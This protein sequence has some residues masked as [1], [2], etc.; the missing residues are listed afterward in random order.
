MTTAEP[1]SPDDAEARHQ[2]LLQVIGGAVLDLVPEHWRRADLVVRMAADERDSALTIYSEDRTAVQREVPDE[3]LD[4][5]AELREIVHVPG[6]GTWFS[7]RCAVNAPDRIDVS[8]NLDHDPLWPSP[9]PAAVW[10]ADLAGHPRDEVFVPYWLREKLD[11][12]TPE[13]QDA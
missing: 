2:E 1:S 11:D 5:F 13:E 7:A 6:R 4:A 10:A 8:Y 9:L 3:V 12:A